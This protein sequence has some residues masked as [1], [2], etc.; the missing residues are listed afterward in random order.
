MKTV[1]KIT[2][3]EMQPKSEKTEKKVTRRKN[4]ISLEKNNLKI[5]I[6]PVREGGNKF[7]YWKIFSN[8]ELIETGN[9]VP[10]R[11]EAESESLKVKRKLSG[12]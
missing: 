4:L 5:K 3:Y 12:E 6:I 10:S 2:S 7:F 9:K 1:F 11:E 8:N